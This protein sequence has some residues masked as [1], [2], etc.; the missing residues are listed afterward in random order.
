MFINSLVCGS[1]TVALYRM[2][3]GYNVTA[4]YAGAKIT[5]IA[6]HDFETISAAKSWRECN[7]PS[8]KAQCK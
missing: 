6:T 5:Q 4:Y 2:P 1:L 7:L 8:I 3:Q